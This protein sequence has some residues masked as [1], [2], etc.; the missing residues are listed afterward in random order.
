ML[1]AIGQPLGG[2]VEGCQ[3]GHQACD[4]PKQGSGKS[5]I[6]TM[7][8][9]WNNLSGAHICLVPGATIQGRVLSAGCHGA[10]LEVDTTLL[11]LL[12]CS[13]GEGVAVTWL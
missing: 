1:G 4:G 13:N 5:E 9:P 11:C 3:S 6:L 12:G 10:V 7:E 8:L 2:Y